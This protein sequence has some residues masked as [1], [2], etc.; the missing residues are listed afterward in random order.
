[1]A[2]GKSWI[3][4]RFQDDAIITQK[5]TKIWETPHLVVEIS[6]LIRSTTTIFSMTE[7]GNKA[8]HVSFS[9]GDTY[10]SRYCATG[11][12][13][14]CTSDGCVKAEVPLGYVIR[15]QTWEY[16]GDEKLVTFT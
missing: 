1:M 6:T 10:H 8:G 16:W 9:V 5:G 3:L 14:V 11:S 7:K 15:K 12:L 2:G 4:E 13:F